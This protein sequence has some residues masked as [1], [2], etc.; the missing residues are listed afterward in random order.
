MREARNPRMSFTLPHDHP[1]LPGHFPGQPLVPA[2]V[3]I[4]H[5]TA[6]ARAAFALGPLAAILRAKFLS[7]V[8]PGEAV[9]LAFTQR[10]GRVVA[11]T[12]TCGAATAFTIEARFAS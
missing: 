9:H 8:R 1:S 11:I 12:G 3:L 7:P 6:A 4:D 2:V 5:A 10:E